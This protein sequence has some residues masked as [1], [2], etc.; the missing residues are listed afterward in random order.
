MLKYLAMFLLG[1][2]CATALFILFILPKE[3]H[4]KF[5]FGRKNGI[6]KG[7]FEAADALQK[8]FGLYDG[9]SPYKVLLSEKTTDVITIETNGVRTVRVIP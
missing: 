8:E 6:V 4:D 3:A 7:R 1:F 5:E 9:H 2:V